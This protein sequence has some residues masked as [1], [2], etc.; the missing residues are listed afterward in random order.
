V[1]PSLA[2]PNQIPHHPREM[3]K[4]ELAV[5]IGRKGYL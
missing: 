1:L 2:Q 4:E 3:E 5:G